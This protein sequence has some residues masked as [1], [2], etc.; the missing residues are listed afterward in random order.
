MRDNKIGKPWYVLFYRKD[1]KG[2]PYLNK[3]GEI[4]I[5]TQ[6]NAIKNKL[7]NLCEVCL[8]L[9]YAE[10][11]SAEVS[12]FMKLSTKQV[13]NSRDV[14]W[15]NQTFQDYQESQ[16]LYNDDEYYAYHNG[17]DSEEGSYNNEEDYSMESE[18]DT[19]ET[20]QCVSQ[21]QLPLL[22]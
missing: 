1:Y 10:N 16:G 13:I 11:H 5:V 15:L 6:G 19:H 20:R 8:Y 12:R 9:G 3:F 4:G 22:H 2:F 14:K 7:V 17:S 21:F 18:N